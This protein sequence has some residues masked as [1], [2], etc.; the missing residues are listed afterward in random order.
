MYVA[1]GNRTVRA[2][3]QGSGIRIAR[4]VIN[5]LYFGILKRKVL[6]R[7]RNSIA[8]QSG[9]LGILFHLVVR[10][11]MALAIQNNIV[12]PSYIKLRTFEIDVR[13]QNDIVIYFI[14]AIVQ[15]CR[16]CPQII[17]RSCMKRNLCRAGSAHKVLQCSVN[18]D[19]ALLYRK[20]LYRGFF[21]NNQRIGSRGRGNFIVASVDCD[22][23]I[24]SIDNQIRKL[25]R[26]IHRCRF[27]LIRRRIRILYRNRNRRHR[28]RYIYTLNSL[29]KYNRS[30]G[31]RGLGNLNNRSAIGKRLVGIG[32]CLNPIHIRFDIPIAEIRNHIHRNIGLFG[33]QVARYHRAVVA[34]YRDARK[35]IVLSHL[36]SRS[37]QER[38][39]KVCQVLFRSR[40]RKDII[41][42]KFTCIPGIVRQCDR[43]GICHGS[44]FTVQRSGKQVDTCRNR[45]KGHRNLFR[46]IR[47][48][49]VGYGLHV[50]RP[51]IELSER[52]FHINRNRFVL[53][54]NNRCRPE[55]CIACLVIALIDITLGKGYIRQIRCVVMQVGL[56]I[57]S[58]FVSPEDK[59]IRIASN[60]PR[61]K[62]R[63]QILYLC[64]LAFAV[65]LAV[66]IDL[67][68][69]AINGRTVA[70]SSC[71]IQLRRQE[72]RNR[73]LDIF[74][75]RIHRF[76]LL[77][78]RHAQ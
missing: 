42:R 26:N 4:T 31:G 63:F 64:H 41:K 5:S 33:Q 57:A 50:E 48:R 40:R 28:H 52:S 70:R 59:L 44:R 53:V 18:L 34:L 10:D 66:K 21:T 55:E 22:G 72:R 71:L 14:A 35:R 20:A 24:R 36:C 43:L 46:D 73:N 69:T 25:A 38:H 16:K 76:R 62:Y 2:A 47:C 61:R 77:T 30:I 9:R 13:L 60:K 54:G 3:Q 1:Y 27:L 8:E 32:H 11:L 12:D 29:G 19:V 7:N 78:G 51:D 23:R 39:R 58:R 45:H 56:Q 65:Q 49:S 74:Q 6:D 68:D 67:H 15:V 37:I 17:R 75:C